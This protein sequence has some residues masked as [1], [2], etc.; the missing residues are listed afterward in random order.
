MRPDR[1]RSTSPAAAAGGHGGGGKPAIGWLIPSGRSNHRIPRSRNGQSRPVA[2]GHSLAQSR[3]VFQYV[4]RLRLDAN[5]PTSKNVA[6]ANAGFVP[7]SSGGEHLQLSILQALESLRERLTA[8]VAERVPD[9][10]DLALVSVVP[11]AGQLRR[12][13]HLQGDARRAAGAQRPIVNRDGRPQRDDG[14]I[15]TTLNVTLTAKAKGACCAYSLRATT[16]PEGNCMCPPM[17]ANDQRRL[18][19]RQCRRRRHARRRRSGLYAPGVADRPFAARGHLY[20]IF[21]DAAPRGLL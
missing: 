17:F 12:Q 14:D 3:I 21:G 10:H 7:S 16:C 8:R 5:R 2:E 18:D 19:R 6:R 1:S 4:S 13:P 9:F 15:P 11:V 20:G